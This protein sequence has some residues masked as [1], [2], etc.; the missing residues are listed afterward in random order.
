MSQRKY[1][2]TLS[3]SL[4]V[5]TTMKKKNK[6]YGMFFLGTCGAHKVGSPFQTEFSS[7]A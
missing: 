1:Q 3:I 2:L 5:A 7:Y 6:K 4:Q